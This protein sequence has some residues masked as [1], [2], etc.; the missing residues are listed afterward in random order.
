MID[1]LKALSNPRRLLKRWWIQ[2]YGDYEGKLKAGVI[3]RPNYGFCLYNAAKLAKRLGYTKI[4]AIEFGVAGGDGLLSFE[5]HAEIVSGL[6]GVGIE[7]YGFDTG[8]GLPG[9]MDYRDLP[10]HWR[11][12]FYRMD[13]N[14]LESRLR[15]AKLVLGNVSATLDGFFETYRPAPIGA[16][17]FDLDFYS[18]TKSAMAVFRGEHAHLMPRIFCYFDDTIG[19][20]LELYSDFT[21]QRLAIRDFNRENDTVKLGFPYY[22]LNEEFSGVWRHQIWVAHLFQH[23]DYNSFV[24]AVTQQLPIQ[25]A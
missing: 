3:A 9:P 16:I 13:V 22:L 12:G 23:P 7:I 11:Q 14:A 2:T 1:A 10:Y 8:E 15:K 17:S 18:S 24:S 6:T 20:E 19:G 5:D 4:S 25:P 21:G